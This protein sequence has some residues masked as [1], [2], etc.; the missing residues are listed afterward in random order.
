MYADLIFECLK[1]FINDTSF[2]FEDLPYDACYDITQITGIIKYRNQ[3]HITT[4][5]DVGDT[6][7]HC[8]ENKRYEK[9]YGYVYDYA[10]SK[11]EFDW[12]TIAY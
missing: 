12:S 10:H 8:F 5:D 4:E 7:V 1:R 11:I 9:L 3:W 6:I 2:E